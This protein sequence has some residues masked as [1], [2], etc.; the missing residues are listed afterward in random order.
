MFPKDFFVFSRKEKANPINKVK[1]NLC[2]HNPLPTQIPGQFPHH[3][4]RVPPL[5][6]KTTHDCPTEKKEKE[7]DNYTQSRFNEC[8]IIIKKKRKERESASRSAVQVSISSA[9]VLYRYSQQQQ[10][11][12]KV[13]IQENPRKIHK[14]KYSVSYKQPVTSNSM[15]KT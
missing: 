14:N 3:Q 1:T 6:S 7:S 5:S 4:I 2:L 8:F 10:R 11:Q 12:K 15:S 9:V 13:N